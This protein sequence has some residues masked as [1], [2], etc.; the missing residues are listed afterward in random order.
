MGSGYS[1]NDATVAVDNLTVN[2]NTEAV[3]AAKEYLQTRPFSCSDLIQ[4]S[5]LFGR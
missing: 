3:Q 4:Q 5:G 2:W 1:A